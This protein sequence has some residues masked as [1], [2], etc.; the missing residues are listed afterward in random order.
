MR[1]LLDS[2]GW[3]VT[4]TELQSWMD[5]VEE[6]GAAAPRSWAMPEVRHVLA[7]GPDRRWR[8][9][10]VDGGFECCGTGWQLDGDG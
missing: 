2:S 3:P 9:R 5:A 10:V 4:W 1:W 7:G 6:G 8:R